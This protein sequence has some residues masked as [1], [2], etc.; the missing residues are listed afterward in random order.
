MSKSIKSMSK[1]RISK[2]KK[3]KSKKTKGRKGGTRKNIKRVSLKKNHKRRR[4]FSKVKHA[5][6]PALKRG[7]TRNLAYRY[8]A[9]RSV[10]GGKKRMMGGNMNAPINGPVGYS[11]DGG[12]VSTWPGVQ[13]SSDGVNTNGATMSNHFSLSPN[14]IVVGGIDPARSTSDDQII[15]SSMTGGKKGRSYKIPHYKNMMAKSRK[16]KHAQKGGFFQEIVN[17]GRG[18]QDELNG[19]YFNL[20]GKQQPISQNPYPTEGQFNNSANQHHLVVDPPNMRDI[21]TTAND[22]V[23][24]I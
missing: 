17:L 3:T 20:I 8:E 1:K 14:G 2:S 24:K 5:S 4:A 23:A 12:N 22:S 13:G 19:G 10:A 16:Y 15:N 7:T 9:Q 21:Y 6:L 11:W 18:A